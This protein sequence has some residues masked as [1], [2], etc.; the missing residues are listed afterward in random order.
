MTLNNPLDAFSGQAEPKIQVFASK[1]RRSS[2]S[3]STFNS[4]IRYVAYWRFSKYGYSR[5][6]S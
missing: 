4:N 5:V 3:I 1:C 2:Q 6:A